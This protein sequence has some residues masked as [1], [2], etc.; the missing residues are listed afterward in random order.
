[1]GIVVFL[2]GIANETCFSQNEGH[3]DLC[4]L[5]EHKQLFDNRI[6]R[7]ESTLDGYDITTNN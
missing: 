4:H 2:H 7:G 5:Q 1:M 6:A 3:T